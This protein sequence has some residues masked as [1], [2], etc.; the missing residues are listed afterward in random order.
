MNHTKAFQF[1]ADQYK[2]DSGSICKLEYHLIHDHVNDI[3]NGN[4]SCNQN[5]KKMFRK[6]ALNR[7]QCLIGNTVTNYEFIYHLG[8]HTI[9]KIAEAIFTSSCRVTSKFA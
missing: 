5:T 6:F 4:V 2:K 3:E 7:F 1:C 9:L 8:H